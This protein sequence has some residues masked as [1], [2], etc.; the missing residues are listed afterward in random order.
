[1]SSGNEVALCV[2]CSNA[3]GDLLTDLSVEQGE[4]LKEVLGFVA[5]RTLLPRYSP[6]LTLS[7]ILQ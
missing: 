7:S 3:I 6:T 2:S 1:M 5:A 4:D